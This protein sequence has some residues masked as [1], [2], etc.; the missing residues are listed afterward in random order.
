VSCPRRRQG[1]PGQV[2]AL[3]DAVPRRCR[4]LVLL[5]TFASLRY[6]EVTALQRGDLDTEVGTVRVRQAFTEVRGSGMVLGPPKS[7]A[8]VRTIAIP[9][10]ILPTLRHHLATYVDKGPAAFVFTGPNGAVIRR[11]NF[12]KLTKWLATVEK[13]GVP[14]LHFHDLRHTGNTLAAATRVSTRDLMA[15]MGHD[16]MSAAIIYQHATSEA[17]RAVAEALGVQ[18]E[19]VERVAGE[20]EKSADGPGEEGSAGGLVRAG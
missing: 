18:V 11:G 7:R 20:T 2:F 8:G 5:T 14:G 19:E 16:S 13:L 17:D 12:N 6:G 1:E 10:P 9:V 3:A 15:R 4:A